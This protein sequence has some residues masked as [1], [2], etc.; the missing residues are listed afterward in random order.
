MLLDRFIFRSHFYPN[1][2]LIYAVHKHWFVIYKSGFKIAF[3]GMLLPVIFF[4]LFSTKFALVIFGAWFLIGFI[5]FL[6]EVADFYFDV[7]LITDRGIVDL[8]WRGI[9]D[10][11]STRVDFETVIG[12]AH[13]KKGFFANILNFG[14]FTIQKDSLGDV[15]SLPFA[16]N[17]F[18][19]EQQTLLTREKYLQ[20]KGLEDE[21]ILK[22]ILSG[23]VKGH[24]QRKREG[25]ADLL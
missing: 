25:L 17:P 15:I 5:R 13:E 3:F 11:S 2:K 10:K 6:Y 21:K 7:L 18:E 20:K 9:F 4:S 1:E 16:A 23:M 8:D 14:D 22:S 24:L 12:A 19:A